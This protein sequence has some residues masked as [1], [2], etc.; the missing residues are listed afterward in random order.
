MTQFLPAALRSFKLL[1]CNVGIIMESFFNT[2]QASVF[3]SVLGGTLKNFSCVTCWDCFFLVFVWVLHLSYGT[4]FEFGLQHVLCSYN[5][6]GRQWVYVWVSSA[7][8][9]YLEASFLFFFLYI[10]RSTMLQQSL[11]SCKFAAFVHSTGIYWTL[12]LWLELF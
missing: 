6:W 10:S 8:W 11:L 2:A 9:Y 5:V 7:S 4:S 3:S 1:V 12:S